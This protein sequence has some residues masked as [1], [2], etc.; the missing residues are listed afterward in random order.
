MLVVT[1]ERNTAVG[2]TSLERCTTGNHNTALGMDALYTTTTGTYNIAIGYQSI[3]GSATASNQCTLGG[4]YT[5]ELRCNDTTISSLSDQ[6]D[7]TDIIDSPYG[8]DFINTVRPVQYLWDTR[9]GNIKDGTTRVGFLAQ[10]LLAACDGDNDTLNLVSEENPDRL[11]A[12]YGNLLPI[13][14]KAIQQ[15]SAQVDALTAR[16]ETLE[17]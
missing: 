16:I 11:E 6:R 10:E 8:L 14:I 7:K 3:S 1:G 9:D 4:T 12:K 17:G 13:A 15:L 5:A 2:R